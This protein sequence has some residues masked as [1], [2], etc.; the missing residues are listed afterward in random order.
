MELVL[1]S[2]VLLAAAFALSFASGSQVSYWEGYE[3]HAFTLEGH[4]CFVVPPAAAAPDKPWVWRTSFPDF[5]IEVDVELL[6]HGYHVGF[7]DCVGMLGADPALDLMDAYYDRVR[8]E[9]GPSVRPA[10]E[11]VGR[12]GLH[13]YRYAARHP[14]RIACI[15]ADTPLLALKL[16]P[17]DDP[18]TAHGW[19]DVMK[20]YSFASEQELFAYRGIPLDLLS[21]IA[22]ARI[23]LRHVVSLNDE[24]VAPEQH[25][26]QACRL[27]R[28]LG[29]DMKV[30]TVAEG[31]ELRGQHFPLPKARESARFIRWHRDVPAGSEEIGNE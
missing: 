18:D 2:L 13:A 30:V 14:E 23:P 16:W 1:L 15:Y 28:E 9:W 19:A 10:L 20:W 5:H 29:H 12:G 3:R 22:E 25:T 7:I 26:F 11:A 24:L 21:V 27:L 31:T 4:P 6:G 8:R 17:R